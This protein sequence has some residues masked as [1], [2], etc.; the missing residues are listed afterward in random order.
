MI[1]IAL[2]GAGGKMGCRIIDHLNSL[3]NY[4]LLCVEVGE[5]G[6]ENL[7]QRKVQPT[8]R[9]AALAD[10]Q[11]VIL[12]LPDRILGAVAREIVPELK[13]G[14][15]VVMLD[16]AVAHAGELPDRSDVSYFVT[17]PCHP[18]VFDHFEDPKARDDFF[19]GVHARQAIVC[20][21]MQGPEEHYKLGETLARDFYAP[22]TRSHRITVEQMAILEPTMSE[23]CGV[24]L[25]TA[26]R[27]VLEEAVRRGV[28]RAAA[29][30][31]MFGHIKV[32][33]G[34]AFSRVEFP[35]SDGALLISEYGRKKLFQPGWKTLF[36]PQSVKEQARMIVKGKDPS[37]Q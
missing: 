21:L 4:R 8:E 22:V 11:V 37:A 36:E 15:M 7:A 32:E 30:D 28:P 6:L 23:T 31:F 3:P 17:H 24:A 10:A 27:E 26:L 33:L 34:I 13:P 19:G 35:F 14:T 2:L 25:V 12:A 5:R 16:P 9:G 1:T 29:E 20:A 18:D